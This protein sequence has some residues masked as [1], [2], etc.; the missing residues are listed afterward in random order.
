V[1]RAD[2]LFQIVQHLRSRRLTTAQQLAQWLEVSERTVYRDIRDLGLSGVPID[3]EA[4]VGYRL[5]KGF[6]LPPI[7]FSFDEVEALVAGARMIQAWGGPALAASSRSAVA[8]I[9]LALPP[10]RRESVE[11]TRLF[12]PQFHVDA[13]TGSM[14]ETA[15]QAIVQKRKLRMVYAKAEEEPEERLVHPFGLHFWGAKWTLVAWCELR[16]DY[17][18]FRLD[19][20][21]NATLTD[22]GF[23]EQPGRNLEDFLAR[24]RAQTGQ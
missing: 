16:Q 21:A 12:A 17:R 3:G 13:H 6:D 15:R 8:K 19:R 2:R 10:D 22:E 18:T 7:M 9:A 20:I 23:R 4:G 5:R 11:S 1:R 24:I 14:L